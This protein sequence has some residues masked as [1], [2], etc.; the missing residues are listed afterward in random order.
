MGGYAGIG[1][2]QPEYLVGKSTEAAEAVSHSLFGWIFSWF[3]W[4]VSFFVFNTAGAVLYVVIKVLLLLLSMFRIFLVI[5]LVTLAATALYVLARLH[6]SKE[7]Q[8][9]LK[10]KSSACLL[11]AAMAVA[12]TTD[13]RYFGFS[14]T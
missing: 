6:R 13:W 2:W 5:Y 8:L 7:H 12:L 14:G 11:A 4:I 3:S 9:I 10:I 1:L